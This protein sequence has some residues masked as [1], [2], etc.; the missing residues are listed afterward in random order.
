MF[1]LQIKTELDE[2]FRELAK[3]ETYEDGA[4]LLA[5]SAL[6]CTSH[7]FR[8]VELATGAVRFHW[9]SKFKP[10]EAER[11][12]IEDCKVIWTRTDY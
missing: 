8:I 11:K 1:S 4:T 10:S 3:S 2:D 5:M 6:C 12:A 9:P 7:Q